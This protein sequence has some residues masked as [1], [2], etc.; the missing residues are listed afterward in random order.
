MIK[1]EHV[2]LAPV[3]ERDSE[4]LF[5][6]INDPALVRLH[7]PFRPVDERAHRSWLESLRTAT[8]QVV[9][10]IRAAS[11]DRLMGIVFLTDIHPVFRSAELRVRLGDAGDRGRGFGTEAVDLCCR[12]GFENFGLQR[13]A[14]HVFSDNAAALR[15]YEKAG[16][17]REGLARRGALI[18]GDW[19]DVVLMARLMPASP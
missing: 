2:A 19:K 15:A 12:F 10:A 6:W 14:L 1:G 7:G 13:I 9:F 17:V 4:L 18:A 8:S 16:F 3:L 5:R 11:D